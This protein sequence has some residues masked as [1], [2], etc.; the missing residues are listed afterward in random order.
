MF[1]TGAIIA[2]MSAAVSCNT[3]LM[4]QRENERREREAR[5][6]Q[7]KLERETKEKIEREAREKLNKVGGTGSPFDDILEEDDDD[8]VLEDDEDD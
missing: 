2:A 8:Y 4:I 3:S 5:E 7:E 1:P 6:R